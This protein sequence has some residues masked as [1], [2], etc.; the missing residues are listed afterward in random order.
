MQ[1]KMIGTFSYDVVPGLTRRTL[2][3]GLVLDEPVDVAKAAIADGKAVRWPPLPHEPIVGIIDENDGDDDSAGQ[4]EDPP[5]PA[6][7]SEA[8]GSKAKPAKSAKAKPAEPAQAAGEPT[9]A[10]AI[11]PGA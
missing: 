4:G 7:D 3:A 9:P 10:E 1:I 11:E 6:A 8:A 5:G 2:H